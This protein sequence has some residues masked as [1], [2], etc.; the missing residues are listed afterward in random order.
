MA[1][2]NESGS[3]SKKDIVRQNLLLATSLDGSMKT[4]AK[5]L[6]TRVVCANTLAIALREGGKAVQISHRSVFDAQAVKMA[7]GVARESFD[8]FIKQAREMAETPIALDE[9]LDV[10]RRVFGGPAPKAITKPNLSWLGDLSKLTDTLLNEESEEDQRESR[11]SARVLELFAG[12][13]MGADLSTSKGTRWGL[14]NAVTQHVDHEMSR[15][16]DTRLDSAWFGR[17]DT[18]KQAAL[19]ALAV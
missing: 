19:Q 8:A 17:G 10:L 15:S 3:I 13:G 6:A 16:Q 18:L 1:S 4:V 9:A 7:L 5:P 11:T 2:T 14:F 12:A